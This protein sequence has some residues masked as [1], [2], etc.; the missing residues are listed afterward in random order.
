MYSQE[1][2]GPGNRLESGKQNEGT[3]ARHRGELYPKANDQTGRGAFVKRQARQFISEP[4]RDSPITNLIVQ[5]VFPHSPAC[6][7][8]PSHQFP[9]PILRYSCGLIL[10]TYSTNTCSVLINLD[11]SQSPAIM[12]PVV[13]LGKL[14]KHREATRLFEPS[15]LWRNRKL[16][17]LRLLRSIRGLG[18]LGPASTWQH[19]EV[20]EPG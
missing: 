14:G 18:S 6:S 9:L 16:F 17:G 12:P 5:L 13:K 2:L 19:T 3:S 8:N 10:S 7:P 1:G 15:K 4:T 20:W 11:A